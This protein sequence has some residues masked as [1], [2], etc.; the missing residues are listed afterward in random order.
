MRSFSLSLTA[1]ILALS[2]HSPLCRAQ[3]AAKP[4]T[5]E[6]P[7]AES[8]APAGNPASDEKGKVMVGG[9]VIKMPAPA[10]FERVDG[11]DT[12]ADKVANAALPASNRYLARFDPQ[13]KADGEK[14]PATNGRSFNAQVLR[15]LE[16]EEIGTT[17]FRQA[18]SGMKAELD[19]LS[20]NMEAEI[21][22]QTGKISGQIKDAAGVD[23]ALNIGNVAVLGY[24][25]D[26]D[27]S[28]GFSL[29][30]NMEVKVADK[31]VKS[32]GLASALLAPVNGRLIYLYAISD[33]HSDADR[34]W[35]EKALVTWRDTVVAANPRVAGPEVRD[36]RVY[37]VSRLAGMVIGAS[38]TAALCFWVVRKFKKKA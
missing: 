30:M 18:K 32:R 23:A 28:L 2:F 20:K 9:R 38:L 33:Y 17:T 31:T 5:P 29:A 36:E 8:A 35:A 1:S 27:E 24:F 13:A 19:Q 16:S 22:K 7:A 26:T 11:Q 25:D 34:Q 15:A 37:R 12:M 14:D 4:E 10:G 6:A 21:A 3:D